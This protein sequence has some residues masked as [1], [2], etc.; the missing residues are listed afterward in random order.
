V[1]LPARYLWPLIAVLFSGCAVQPDRE[2]VA[3]VDAAWAEH[4]LSVSSLRDWRALGRIAVTL[5]SDGGRLEMDWQQSPERSRINL[6]APF[7]QGAIRLS[8]NE[9]GV[10]LERPD[11]PPLRGSNAEWLLERA[12]GWRVPVDRLRK[13]MVGLPQ[14]DEY[15]ELDAWGRLARV[16]HDGWQVR[17]QGYREVGDRELPQRIA[18]DKDELSIRVVVSSWNAEVGRAPSQRIAIPGVSD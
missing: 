13:W 1:S 11:A 7:G 2:S 16:E 9:N 8:E 6:I 12:T 3:D 14:L 10:L 4:R 18:L 15:F 17:Y 5:P